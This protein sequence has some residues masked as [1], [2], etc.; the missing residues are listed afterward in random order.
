L[1]LNPV[2]GYEIAVPWRDTPPDLSYWN[3]SA[4]KNL[5]GS[6]LD[7]R[8]FRG[9]KNALIH[10]VQ[11]QALERCLSALP[12]ADR[13]LDFGCGRGRL[14][15]LLSRHAKETVGIDTGE[16]L[17]AA[18]QKA[19][20]APTI[21]FVHYGGEHL[22]FGSGEFD[23][24]LSVGVMQFMIVKAE[25]RALL[26]ELA[27]CLRR[28]GKL[29]LLEQTRATRRG[30]RASVEGYATTL[31]EHGLRLES[32][33]PVRNGRDVLTYAVAFGAVP[34]RLLPAAA[35]LEA[36]LARRSAR[37]WTHYRDTLLVFGKS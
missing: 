36:A 8:D 6:V 27:A 3:A 5:D 7:P 13:A 25:H 28:G 11:E 33:T 32:S 34:R 20:E 16:T 35:R 10:L 24:A 17:L 37:P 29:V 4:T 9:H 15:T 21:R 22:P 30:W 19:C 23:L 14:T 2:C 12:R 18:A 26:G 1:F 31:G